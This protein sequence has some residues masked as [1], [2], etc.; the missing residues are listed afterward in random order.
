MS[1]LEKFE[2]GDGFTLLQ[3][4]RTF[5]FIFYIYMMSETY[6]I[7]YVLSKYLQ[8]SNIPLTNAFTQVNITVESF[9]SLRN[10]DCFKR[11]CNEAVKICLANYIYIDVPIEKCKR[12]VLLRL[13]SGNVLPNNFT[14][15]DG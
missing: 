1:T 10:E 4:I 3:V 15:Q 9:Q 8:S 7:V 5:D 2:T 6:L 13:G 14:I 12:K 11:I